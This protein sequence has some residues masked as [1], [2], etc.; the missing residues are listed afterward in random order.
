MSHSSNQRALGVAQIISGLASSYYGNAG[1][2]A[3]VLGKGIKNVQG[4]GKEEGG[5][6]LT[7]KGFL[8]DLG[9]YATGTGASYLG[10]GGFGGG[11]Y[12]GLAMGTAGGLAYGLSDQSKQP[13]NADPN[14]ASG[15]PWVI[16][17]TKDPVYFP[18]QPN[19]SPRDQQRI[20]LLAQ[21][22]GY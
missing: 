7:G 2:G 5:S 16:G 19:Y 12:G 6:S 14:S 4:K 22:G 15:D 18:P 9:G 20:L 17:K 10:G 13:K 21:M 3:F 8:N 11:G 1:G